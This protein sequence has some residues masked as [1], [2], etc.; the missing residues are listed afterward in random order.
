MMFMINMDGHG[1]G[2]LDRQGCLAVV[3]SLLSK[4][5]KW[6]STHAGLLVSIVF[7][8]NAFWGC[9]GGNISKRTLVLQ[10]LT[11]AVQLLAQG[12]ERRASRCVEY[13]AAS[14]IE[15]VEP[16]AASKAKKEVG[17]FRL[18]IERL[19]K[20][21]DS[22]I[23]RLDPGYSQEVL[24]E[25]GLL[26]LPLHPVWNDI[27]GTDHGICACSDSA[28]AELCERLCGQ[29]RAAACGANGDVATSAGSAVTNDIAGG[30]ATGSGGS[31]S[32]SSSSSS[33]ASASSTAAS[34]AAAAY[35]ALQLNTD[36]AEETV[37]TGLRH[38]VLRLF[39]SFVPDTPH[40]ARCGSPGMEPTTVWQSGAKSIAELGQPPG[41]VL[42]VSDAAAAGSSSSNRGG[43]RAKSALRGGSSSAAGGSGG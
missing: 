13:A 7:A 26:R 11:A 31:S 30:D 18:L 22:S 42:G 35:G 9:T 23:F 41:D 27:F 29:A 20:D 36:D 33:A 4:Q 3:S 37:V 6:T 14:F 39:D 25:G 21:D 2:T 12:N 17:G 43:K 16:S 10:W 32:S 15:I 8:S 38:A 24:R 1:S 34:A 5:P 19:D 40:C 28:G